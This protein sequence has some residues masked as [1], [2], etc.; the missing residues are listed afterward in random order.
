MCYLKRVFQF[1]VSI[2]IN[3]H[4]SQNFL[5]SRQTLSII[6]FTKLLH[7]GY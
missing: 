5:Y 7:G 2:L 6:G 1:D 3:I 4:Q